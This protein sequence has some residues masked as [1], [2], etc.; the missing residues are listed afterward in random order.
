MDG[1]ITIPWKTG[2]GNIVLAVSGEE[3]RISSDTANARLAREQ[4]VTF[5]AGEATATLTVVQ[6]GARVVLRDSAGK[7]IRD[8]EG[9]TLTVK[10]DG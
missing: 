8:N 9:R 10:K 2:G 4:V 1:R 3:V 6:K 5:R 7:V